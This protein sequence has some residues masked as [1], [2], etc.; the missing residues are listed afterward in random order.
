MI[1][2]NLQSGDI[3]HLAA[4]HAKQGFAYDLPDLDSPLF[5]VRKVATN[6]R[7]IP[8]AGAALRLT[9]EA[10]LLIDPDAENKANVV[11]ALHE[12]V[13]RAAQDAGLEDV[14]ALLPSPIEKKFGWQLMRLGWKRHEWT[15]Y[16]RSVTNG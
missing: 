5:V 10:F 1:I 7:S 14:Q 13:R 6:G 12:A 3:E 2:R 16:S 11:L 9:A 4:I 8:V 15:L